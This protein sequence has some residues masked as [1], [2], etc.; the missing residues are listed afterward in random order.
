LAAELK[1]NFD[2][3][4]VLFPEGKGIFDVIADGELIYS[5][6]KTDRFPEPNE[7]TKLLKG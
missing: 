2:E 5:K 1:S 4:A 3:E 6:Y 7:V